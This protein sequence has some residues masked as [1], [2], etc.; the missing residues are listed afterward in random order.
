MDQRVSQPFDTPPRDSLPALSATHV[1]AM[2]QSQ[3][4]SAW[5]TL[6]M[7]YVVLRTVGRRSGKEHKVALPF[8]RDPDGHRI[9]MGSYAASPTHPAWYLN[10]ADRDANPDVHVRVQTGE[11]RC[12][13]EILEGDEHARMWALLLE[14]RP[15]YADYQRQ[16]ERKIPMV[17]LREPDEN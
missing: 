5:I 8:W 10:L 7:H 11:Y 6:N 17:R 14:D 13:P 2:E 15:F 4:D 1:E 9:V 3:D 12:V 16:I